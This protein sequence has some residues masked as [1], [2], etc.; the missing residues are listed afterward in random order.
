[1]LRKMMVHM[2]GSQGNSQG[3]K[4]DFFFPL[5]VSP[6]KSYLMGINIHQ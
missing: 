5:P 1:M 2:E 6:F 4:I 3:K